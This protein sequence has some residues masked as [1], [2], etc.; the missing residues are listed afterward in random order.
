M[1]D[2]LLSFRLKSTLTIFLCQSDVK[3]ARLLLTD[4]CALGPVRTVS[5]QN[6]WSL[7][8][9]KTIIDIIMAFRSR[10]KLFERGSFLER[11]RQRDKQK[12]KYSVNTEIM[13]IKTRDGQVKLVNSKGE[14]IEKDIRKAKPQRS[15]AQV[16][17]LLSYKCSF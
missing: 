14:V 16:D 4:N 6:I 11:F 12:Q 9:L 7:T 5:H 3:P 17:V 13:T 8:L 1:R 2:C 15:H 10:A